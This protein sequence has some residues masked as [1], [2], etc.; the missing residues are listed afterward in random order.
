MIERKTCMS[1]FKKASN[2]SETAMRKLFDSVMNEVWTSAR[3]LTGSSEKA[4]QFMPE[5]TE[6]IMN[7]IREKVF[8]DIGIFRNF[9]IGCAGKVC[10]KNDIQDT[11][12]VAGSA[13]PEKLQTELYSGNY[14]NGLRYLVTGLHKLRNGERYAVVLG[15]MGLGVSETSEVLK[16]NEKEVAA[17]WNAGLRALRTSLEAEK[18]EKY[19]IHIPKIEQ[20]KDL[21]D[22]ASE[23][24]EVKEETQILCL[25]VISKFKIRNNARKK[26]FLFCCA[27][28]A[29]IACSVFAIYQIS[30][31][32]TGSLLAEIDI[33]DY[34]KIVVRLDEDSAPITVNNFVTLAES[35]F[36]NG[37]TFHRIMEGF[38][39]Q[40]GDPEG[41]GF[42]G[43]ENTI[44]GEFAANGV[45]NT[46][47]HTRGAISMA[48]SQD[49][50]SASSQFFIMQKDYKSLD[51]YYACFGYVTEGLDVVDAV[52]EAA[53]P[54]DDNGSISPENQP[55]IDSIKIIRK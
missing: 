4:D 22:K 47:S 44:K 48:R 29:V 33:R 23:K 30:N 1:L 43:S 21:L 32:D 27:I 36:Y 26:T 53:E 14:S 55:V 41:T 52:C 50:N 31:K 49:Y 51:G 17:L 10:Y 38:M 16:R 18:R 40:G 24:A 8:P 12:P 9:A 20:I 11:A 6:M 15:M 25:S 46:L 45:K 3:V 42:G 37:L 54:T 35:G 39:M 7:G 2:G 13:T 28:I 34:G 19:S 5:I